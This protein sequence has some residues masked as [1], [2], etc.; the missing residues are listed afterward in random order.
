MIFN[1]QTSDE[2]SPKKYE[3]LLHELY[4]NGF[5]MQEDRWDHGHATFQGGESLMDF[6]CFVLIVEKQYSSSTI[7]IYFQ[8]K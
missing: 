3:N 2:K 5:K 1:L 7:S 4:A 8:E 6:Q